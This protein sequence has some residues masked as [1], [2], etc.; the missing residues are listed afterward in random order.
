MYILDLDRSPRKWSAQAAW[1]LIK[2]LTSED[3]IRYNEVLLS[4]L[5]KTDG[6]A[7]LQ[8]MEQAELITI[9]SSNG[10]P[11]SIK[12]GKPVYRAAF[13][14]LVED[15]VLK[16]RLDLAI[17]SELTAIETKNIG[18]YE[19]ELGMLGS[20]PNQPRAIVP[21]IEWLLAKLQAS[22]AKVDKYERESELLKMVLQ[23]EY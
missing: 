14:R 16:S 6:E 21:R 4:D 7:D 19:A 2:A 9:I 13:R 23:N 11:H 1:Y 15:K 10:R 22:Q 18:K 8:A 3:Q 12:P 20:L 5:Y 17:L